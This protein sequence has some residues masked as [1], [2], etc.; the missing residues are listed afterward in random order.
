[1]IYTDS[2]IRYLSGEMT[3]DEARDFKTSLA[4]NKQIKFEHDEI[5]KAL[6]LIENNLRTCWNKDEMT[7]EEFIADLLAKNDILSFSGR[8]ER[9]E[10]V[11]FLKKLTETYEKK[12]RDLLSGDS[13]PGLLLT[14]AAVFIGFLVYFFHETD[15]SRLFEK[16]YLPGD[17]AYICLFSRNG[18]DIE[19]VTQYFLE[20][21]YEQALAILSDKELSGMMQ[22]RDSLIL[23]MILYETGQQ[24]R[25]L[26]LLQSIAD[27]PDGNYKSTASW[28]YALYSLNTGNQEKAGQYL[29]QL[30]ENKSSYS[31]DARKLM[32]RLNRTH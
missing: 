29:Q 23:S 12:P 13:R 5:L 10:E 17:D 25:S 14:A 27:Q 28:Y 20:G 3:E 30:A 19:S 7:R 21:R 15:T 31:K 9:P 18:S 1:M 24:S 4:Q 8:E 22:T 6:K 11:Q 26:T 2:I 16:Y 32:R